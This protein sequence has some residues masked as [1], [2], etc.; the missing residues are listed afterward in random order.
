M[1]SAMSCQCSAHHPDFNSHRIEQRRTRMRDGRAINVL[2][3]KFD[4][5]RPDSYGCI[6][7]TCKGRAKGKRSQA[8]LA[9]ELRYDI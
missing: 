4:E 9:E 1:R 6:D 3:R 7:V 5:D 8:I 2:L